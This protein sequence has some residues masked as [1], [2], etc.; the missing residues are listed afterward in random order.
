MVQEDSLR[1]V[2]D[3]FGKGIKRWHTIIISFFFV[4]QKVKKLVIEENLLLYTMSSFEVLT[5]NPHPKQKSAENSLHIS[6]LQATIESYTNHPMEV[7]P[8][9]YI[10][11]NLESVVRQV[12]KEYPVVL[13][14]GP[15]QGEDHDA[16]TSYGWYRPGVCIPG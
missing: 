10:A 8:M 5:A 15:R 2:A 7:R 1:T 3:E 6:P 16:E 14:T 11:Q 4:F 13:V 12:T 9:N